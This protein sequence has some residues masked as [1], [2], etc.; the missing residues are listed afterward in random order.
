MH[1]EKTQET[2]WGG[3]LLAKSGNFWTKW[4]VVVIDYKTLN[5]KGSHKSIL[6][7]INEW[8]E[9]SCLQYIAKYLNGM[10]VRKSP[11]CSHQSHMTQIGIINGSCNP[12]VNVCR[13]TGYPHS[14]K[15]SPT[16]YLLITRGKWYLWSGEIWLT[17]PQPDDQKHHQ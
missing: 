14:L 4:I 10:L 8:K 3:F 1:V 13:G 17:S 15:V 6:I 5:L 7:H 12:W 16:D 9:R 2:A 11:F